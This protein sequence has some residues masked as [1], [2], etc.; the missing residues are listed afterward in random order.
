MV[1][2]S[3]GTDVIVTKGII[4]KMA[5]KSF[6]YVVL[7]LALALSYPLLRFESLP[8]SKNSLQHYLL[9]NNLL[10]PPNYHKLP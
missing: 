1:N 10:A 4:Y 2:V 6:L 8:V 5:E 9:P 3:K 7:R